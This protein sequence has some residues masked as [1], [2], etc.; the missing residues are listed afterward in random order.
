MKVPTFLIHETVWEYGKALYML[1]G[2]VVSSLALL[3]FS[4]IARR[5][6]H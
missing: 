4:G 5:W 1:V 3:T 2:S 6:E